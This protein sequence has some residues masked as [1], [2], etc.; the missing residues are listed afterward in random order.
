MGLYMQLVFLGSVFLYK[1]GFLA[2]VV[3]ESFG[4]IIF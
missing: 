4:Y 1:S 2:Y 3:G